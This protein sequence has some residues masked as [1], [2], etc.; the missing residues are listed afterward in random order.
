MGALGR[1]K[2]NV[3]NSKI[4][5][6]VREAVGAFVTMLNYVDEENDNENDAV[7]KAIE[8][9]IKKVKDNPEEVRNIQNIAKALNFQTDLL[10]K[11]IENEYRENNKDEEGYNKIPNKIE[12]INAEVSEKDALN[13]MNDRQKGGKEKTR[14]DE[15]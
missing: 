15:D 10:D 11:V 6:M 12:D 7:N 14:V 1:V 9:T 3:Q 2:E 8:D 13:K 5:G 4:A